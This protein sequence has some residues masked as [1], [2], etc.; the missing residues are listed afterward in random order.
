MLKPDYD[1]IIYWMN[2]LAV[3]CPKPEDT[4]KVGEK[5]AAQLKGGEFIELIGD[6]GSGK[7]T[8]VKGLASGLGSNDD[9]TSP[10]FALKN[11]YKGRLDLCHFDLYRLEE[12]GIINHEIKDSIS[13]SSVVAIEWAGASSDILPHDRIIIEFSSDGEH[14]RKLKITYL[15]KQGEEK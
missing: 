8:F 2:K 15:N 11:V 6:L 9:V 4:M 5:L 12:P 13:D 3:T 14:S 1:F 10:S 7:T